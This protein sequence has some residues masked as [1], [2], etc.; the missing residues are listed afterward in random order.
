MNHAG[1]CRSRLLDGLCR[2]GLVGRRRQRR[3]DG[4]RLDAADHARGVI[5]RDSPGMAMMPVPDGD[6]MAAFDDIVGRRQ[7]GAFRTG[8]HG[9]ARLRTRRR[10]LVNDMHRL[11]RVL[12]VL[13]LAA[14]RLL[15]IVNGAPAGQCG[16]GADRGDF[17]QRCS[18]RGHGRPFLNCRS[19]AMAPRTRPPAP[20]CRLCPRN[21][22]FGV[23]D[24]Y[25]GARSAS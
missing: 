8:R 4:A 2:R 11:L 18:N 25:G 22:L 23:L 13:R 17:Q 12:D 6:G 9:H 21:E 3:D 5:D 24:N 10:R 16:T 19:E 1:A 15:G 7:V 14:V 20:L